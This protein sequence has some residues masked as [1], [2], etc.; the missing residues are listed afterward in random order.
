MFKVK[1]INFASYVV[2]TIAIC[3]CCKDEDVHIAYGED[4]RPAQTEWVMH[5]GNQALTGFAQGSL[6]IEF[7]VA[8][9]FNGKSDII[10]SAVIQGDAVYVVDALDGNVY[11]LN[12]AT[13]K[14][15]W[16][17]PLD[18]GIEATPLIIDAILYVGSENEYFYAL[19]IETG[20]V[21]WQQKTSGKIM[22]GANWFLDIIDNQKYII[23]GSYDGTLYSFNAKHG[24]LHWTYETDNYIN[25]TSAIHNG[26]IAFGGCDAIIHFVSAKTGK[27]LGAI[28]TEDYIAG[29]GAID[30]E[31]IYIGNYGNTFMKVNLE[32]KKTDWTFKRNH[33]FYA[34][35]AIY[36][37]M[38][39]V[40][41]R[42][43]NIYCLDKKTG[44]V[45]WLYHTR[46]KID[47]SPVI[48]D[49][50]VISGSDDGRLYLIDLN[51]GKLIWQYEL[52]HKIKASPAIVDGMIYI[53]TENGTF[54][55]F[56][57]K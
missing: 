54:W 48:C 46:G 4:N 3:G 56:K 47:S 10:A 20:N 2:F 22:S 39:V 18:C 31:A 7:E 40:A 1:Y 26:L 23:C 41:C 43:K 50:K 19:D 29:S 45:L 57:K 53:G 14:Q 17:T 34:S 52:G 28:D 25:G 24:D 44:E 8:W 36:K 30:D 13:G 5:R 12:K 21:V 15:I 38:V 42:D 55:A 35:P 27:E 32:T 49:N 6:A 51:S 16:I 9:Q 37:N 11:A 33:E